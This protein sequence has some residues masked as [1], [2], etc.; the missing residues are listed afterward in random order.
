MIHVAAACRLGTF[1]LDVAF[2]SS[3]RRTVL[4]GPSGAGKTMTLQCMAGFLVPPRG[5]VTIDD[6]VLLDTERG[7]NVPPWRRRVGAVLQGDGL[8][9]HLTVAENVTF[10]MRPLWRGREATRALALLAAVGLTGYAERRPADLSAG[11]QQRVALARALASDPRAL[12]LDEPFAGVDAAVREQLRR[13]LLALV[14]SRGLPAVVVTHDFDEAHVLGELI[15]VLVAGRVVQTGGPADVARQPRTATVA[16]LVGA[17][18]V[19]NADVVGRDGGTAL[20][21][22]GP[23]R[24]RAPLRAEL[25]E[26]LQVCVRPEHLHLAPPESAPAAAVHAHV[27]RVLPRRAGATVL[28]IAGGLELEAWVSGAPPAPGD[29]VGVSITDG[30]AHA[31][32]PEDREAEGLPARLPT[33]NTVRSRVIGRGR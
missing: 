29:T 8:F 23:L 33:Y 28:L 24:F 18:N 25:G 7:I 22:V 21:G 9:P 14:E 15:V 3:C 2:H 32:E 11:E 5:Y 10:G 12:L 20:L 13:D 17:S 27:H 16:R 31:L 4:F 19:L 6:A 1:T 26:H 30:V